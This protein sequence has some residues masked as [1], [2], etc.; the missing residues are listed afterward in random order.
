MCGL[1]LADQAPVDKQQQ[2]QEQDPVLGSTDEDVD[3]AVLQQLFCCPLT[4]VPS[5]ALSNCY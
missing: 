5:P 1:S 2:S 3:A 4:K